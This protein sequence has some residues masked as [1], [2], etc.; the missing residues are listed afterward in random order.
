MTVTLFYKGE[1]M[2]YHKFM[3][4]EA[5]FEKYEVG[6]KEV[7]V[8]R[9]DKSFLPPL[10]PN[11]KMAALYALVERA[12]KQGYKEAVLFA[13][14]QHGISYSIG[15][16]VFCKEFGLKSIVVMPSDNTTGTGFP[17]W[18]ESLVELGA[19]RIGIK[20]NMVTINVNQAKKFAEERKAYFVPFGFDD[21]L[22]VE[23]HA[24]HFSLPQNVGCLVLSTMTGMI[25]A[26]TLK[27]IKDRGYNVKTVNAV[28]G[29]RPV[30]SIL[31]SVYKYLDPSI[32]YCH[33]LNIHNPYDRNFDA[34]TALKNLDQIPFDL[35][36]DYEAKAWLWLVTNIDKL[37][38]PICFINI[39]R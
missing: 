36:P 23:V 3:L 27:Q 9:D 32:S 7:I 12:S 31:K 26:G 6:G 22:S 8:R 14:K 39:G 33:N 4:P 15:F 34:I 16:P 24:N 1:I 2:F 5:W 17:E 25:L 35:H 28:S 13:K 20:P 18:S 10:P 21:A 38:E 11:A 29:G 30:G 19:Y 37:R